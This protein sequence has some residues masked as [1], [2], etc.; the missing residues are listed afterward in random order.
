MDLGWKAINQHIKVENG[1]LGYSWLP[2]FHIIPCLK[3]LFNSI[4]WVVIRAVVV[5]D[6]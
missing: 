5:V 1:H 4:C 6:Q 3:L 2:Q